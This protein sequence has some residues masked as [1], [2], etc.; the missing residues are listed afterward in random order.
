MKVEL[1]DE[2]RGDNLVTLTRRIERINHHRSPRD[3]HKSDRKKTN[4]LLPCKPRRPTARM[5][6]PI[7]LPIPEDSSAQRS[8]AQPF[9][10]NPIRKGEQISESPEPD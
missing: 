7:T 10:G 4:Y 5:R 3:P 2:R 9:L 1:N 8:G 6:N